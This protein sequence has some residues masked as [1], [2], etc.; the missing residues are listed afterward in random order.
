[1]PPRVLDRLVGLSLVLVPACFG[2][3][4]LAYGQDANWDLRNYHWYNPY[5]FLTDRLGRDLGAAHIATFYNPLL[6]LPLYAVGQVLPAKVVGVLLGVLQGLNY[7]TLVALA[8]ILFADLLPAV[9]AGQRRAAAAAAALVGVLGGGHLS[10]VGATFNDN[11]ISLFVLG[12]AIVVA[13]RAAAIWPPNG[14]AWLG[15]AVA[16]PVAAAG[17]LMGIA[18]GLK[19]PT[20]PFAVGFCL[21]FLCVAGGLGRRIALAFLFGLGVLVGFAAAGGPWMAML[22]RDYANPLFPY[23]NGF[24]KSPL[25]VAESY[26]DTRFVP[27]DWRTM[28]AFPFVFSRDPKAVGEIDFRDL[29]IACAYGALLI[30]GVIALVRGF[31]REGAMRL[32]MAVRFVA[33]AAVLSFLPWMLIFGIYRYIIPLEMLAPLVMTALIA[34]WPAPARVRLALVAAL[35][36][37][38]TATI[39]RGEWIHAPWQDGPFV[40][41]I[42]PS[43]AEPDR[44]LAVITGTDPVAWVIPSFPP[45]IPFIRIYGYLNAPGQAKNGLNDR[46]RGLIDG[47]DGAFYLLFPVKERANAVESLAAYGLAADFGD[48]RPVL[49]NLGDY[50]RWCRVYRSSNPAV[51]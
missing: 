14:P 12:A 23:F 20:A 38:V 19:L 6:D 1:M 18:V 7:V 50:V 13:R 43:V 27:G 40:H 37:L 36:A 47:H 44:T 46:A 31:R 35:F 25:G 26:R 24:F 51:R 30:T 4:A 34:A 15:A 28:L 48:C 8:D 41:V 42:A 21:A 10:M 3:M 11:L 39:R 49:S 9:E 5:A 17:L 45:Q 32:S 29:R 16:L 2:A 22:W 33:A